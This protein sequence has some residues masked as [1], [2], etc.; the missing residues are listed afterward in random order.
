MP[1]GWLRNFGSCSVW[2]GSSSTMSASMRPWSFSNSNDHI[3]SCTWPFFGCSFRPHNKWSPHITPLS[4]ES[5]SNWQLGLLSCYL[6][7]FL[8]WIFSPLDLL[9]PCEYPVAPFTLP[10]EEGQTQLSLETEI[11]V[12]WTT[13]PAGTTAHFRTD[14][15]LGREKD[16]SPKKLKM[17]TARRVLEPNC[18]VKPRS[19]AYYVFFFLLQIA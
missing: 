14:G 3:F 17:K 8:L 1:L 12:G 13:T 16:L 5:L 9:F 18:L 7:F 4:M 15:V 2:S 19:C 11:G 10:W 6:Y